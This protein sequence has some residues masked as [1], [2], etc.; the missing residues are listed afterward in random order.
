M[1][2]GKYFALPTLAR[3]ISTLNYF[4]KKSF[5]GFSFQFKENSFNGNV[6]HIRFLFFLCYESN[7]IAGGWIIFFIYLNY[8]FRNN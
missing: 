6:L 8:I 4:P 7:D 5:L 2:T 1:E 3:G